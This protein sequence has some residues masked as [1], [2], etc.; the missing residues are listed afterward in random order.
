MAAFGKKASGPIIANMRMT[1]L[2]VLL[3]FTCCTS[4][5]HVRDSAPTRVEIIQDDYQDLAN[6]V[7]EKINR[8]GLANKL[9]VSVNEQQQLVRVFFFFLF[10]HDT[11]TF[12]F[13]FIGLKE[14]QTK[15][16]SYGFETL[17]GRDHY[18]NQVWPYVIECGDLEDSSVSQDR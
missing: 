1:F 14:N 13:R 3:L 11:E 16:E 8:S 17:V 7:A 6:C 9:R 2:P 15:V 18:P 12:E 5:V 10:I 4:S